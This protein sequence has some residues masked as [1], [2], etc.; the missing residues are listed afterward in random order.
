MPI[1]SPLKSDQVQRPPQIARTRS[2][3]FDS[4]AGMPG[5]TDLTIASQSP[6]PSSSRACAS[7]GALASPVLAAGTADLVLVR[8]ISTHCISLPSWPFMKQVR[9]RCS[10]SVRTRCRMGLKRIA[11]ECPGLAFS[12]VPRTRWTSLHVRDPD[13]DEALE[14]VVA[15]R[16]PSQTSPWVAGHRIARAVADQLGLLDSGRLGR[17]LHAGHAASPPSC[18][19]S[20]SRRA[21]RAHAPSQVGHR[22]FGGGLPLVRATRLNRGEQ[23]RERIRPATTILGKESAAPMGGGEGCGCSRRISI[24]HWPESPAGELPTGRVPRSSAEDG[25]EHAVGEAFPPRSAITRQPASVKCTE[26]LL[27]A[28]GMRSP[29]MSRRPSGCRAADTVVGADAGEDPVA[30]GMVEGARS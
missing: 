22:G 9:R 14:G 6:T 24:A 20:Q 23:R 29:S 26:S 25:S 12:P 13:P 28:V 16:A 2:L 17:F 8:T 30:N 11:A 5:M 7:L 15:E 18:S 1:I 27:L 4:L 19:W 10:R 21:G 3:H